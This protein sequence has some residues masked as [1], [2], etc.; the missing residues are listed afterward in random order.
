MLVDGYNV[1]PDVILL[2]GKLA[3]LVSTEVDDFSLDDLNT[4]VPPLYSFYTLQ[5]HILSYQHFCGHSC[6]YRHEN[7]EHDASVSRS[8]HYFGDNH[9][10]N[11]TL[12][13]QT[14]AQSNP[15]VD[16]Y[17]ATSAGLV[18][19]ARLEDS[20]ARNPDVISTSKEFI[21]RTGE[22]GFYLSVMGNA[23]TG[24]AP[25]ECV[26]LSFILRSP[27][28]LITSLRL[29]T[30]RIVLDGYVVTS[31]FSSAKN[32]SPSLRA[33]NAPTCLSRLPS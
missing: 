25:K 11:G 32:A 24:V 18:M 1:Q 30:D 17:N 29:L 28:L 14:L 3:L 19:K 2:A 6:Y 20:I 4:Y 33:G 12:F 16:Y 22:S 10:F 26:L 7:I 9:S 15:G 21:L 8:D 27:L 23:T 13:N 31:T 5:L